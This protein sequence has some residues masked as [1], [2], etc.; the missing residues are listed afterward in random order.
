MT[1]RSR[2]P[3]LSLCVW[4]DTE[5]NYQSAACARNES[6]RHAVGDLEPLARGRGCAAGGMQPLTVSW[7]A[8]MIRYLMISMQPNTS[9]D[10]HPSAVEM[11]ILCSMVAKLAKRDLEVRLEAENAEISGLAYAVLAALRH[12]QA[13][14]AE[15]S[16]KMMLTPAT[17]V[18]VVDTL[19]EQGLVER[20]QDP[21]DRRRTPLFVTPAG[22]SLLE[23]VPLVD[24]TDSLVVSLENLGEEATHDLLHLLRQLA[25]SL[26][27][28]EQAIQG[29]AAAARTQCGKTPEN[30]ETGPADSAARAPSA[31][32]QGE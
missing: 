18:P 17:L 2:V 13:T 9:G 25:I 20:R 1:A 16:R 30:S 28:N 22:R 12:R 11:R 14:S 21:D 4:K 26:Y 8:A 15:I 6:G 3:F 10:L 5:I 27:G 24:D 29:I 31:K 19:E 23:R 7:V 32:E